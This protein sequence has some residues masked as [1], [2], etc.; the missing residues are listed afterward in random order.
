MVEEDWYLRGRVCAGVE[1]KYR[2]EGPLCSRRPDKVHPRVLGLL[3]VT[4]VCPEMIRNR[5]LSSEKCP[6]LWMF[7]PL[8]GMETIIVVKMLL[9]CKYGTLY[10]RNC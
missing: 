3:R 10:G 4:V 6:C 7:T 1:V 8:K 9:L 2:F 5:L